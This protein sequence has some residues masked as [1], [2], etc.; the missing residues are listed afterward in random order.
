[1]PWEGKR[2]ATVSSWFLRPR[3]AWRSLGPTGALEPLGLPVP[4]ACK[5]GSELELGSHSPP[6]GL[7]ANTPLLRALSLL[8]LTPAS[9]HTSGVPVLSG[10]GAGRWLCGRCRQ[11]LLGLLWA[12]S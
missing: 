2:P 6:G 1:M 11:D 9:V 7:G 12:Q 8:S 5:L 4:L 10:R 3:G